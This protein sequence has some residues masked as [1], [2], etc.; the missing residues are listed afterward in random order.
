VRLP[1]NALIAIIACA[2]AL[3]A[4]LAVTYLLV[5]CQALPSLLGPVPGDPHPRTKLGAALLV[6]AV[7]LASAGL[8]L[9]RLRGRDQ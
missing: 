1:R 8:N 9:A 7:L 4:A 3:T 2:A 6:I 5:A